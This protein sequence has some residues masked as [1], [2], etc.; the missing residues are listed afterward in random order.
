MK[1]LLLC[2]V[3]CLSLPTAFAG[4]LANQE[5]NR[6]ERPFY[7][8]ALAGYGHTTWGELISP[9][10]SWLVLQSTPVSTRDNGF[11]WGFLGGY[12]VSP[13]FAVEASFVKFHDSDVY[14]LENSF[15]TPIDQFRSKTHVFTLSGKFMVP[16]PR[17]R[18][19]PYALAGVSLTHRKDILA[20]KYRP[21]AIFGVGLMKDINDRFSFDMSFQYVTGYGM[22]ELKPAIDYIPFLIS[23]QA[24]IIYHFDIIHP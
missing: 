20:N 6:V 13:N 2:F 5:S 15:Y 22:S 9:E 7:I 3:V 4:G 10:Q 19:A 17:W 18:V 14:F 23:G 12:T 24:R 1:R 16:V 11:V 21:G 8:G